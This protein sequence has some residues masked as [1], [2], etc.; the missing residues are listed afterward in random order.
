MK[1]ANMARTI[2]YKDRETETLDFTNENDKFKNY[3]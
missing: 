3:G 2:A 1:V